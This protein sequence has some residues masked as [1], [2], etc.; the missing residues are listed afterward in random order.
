MTAGS[1][2][3]TIKWGSIGLT[4]IS[5]LVGLQQFP[6]VEAV[7]HLVLVWSDLIFSERRSRLVPDH[8]STFRWNIPSLSSASAAA[9]AS[10]VCSRTGGRRNLATDLKITASVVLC[11]E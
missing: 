2:L 11:V 4:L 9:A 8:E 3:Q 7:E 5:C 1:F 10:E 6:I